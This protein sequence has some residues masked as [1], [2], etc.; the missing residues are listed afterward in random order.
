MAIMTM[1]VIRK[2]N[3]KYNDYDCIVSVTLI[4]GIRSND[5][6]YD[7]GVTIMRVTIA[8]VTMR[9]HMVIIIVIRIKK[10]NA[11]NNGSS[12]NNSENKKH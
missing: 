11:K 9:I 6:G 5:Y 12:N 2:M 7:V 1:I 4:M 10:R 8:A 3:R